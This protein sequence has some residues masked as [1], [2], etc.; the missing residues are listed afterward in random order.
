MTVSRNW[1]SRVRIAPARPIL[2]RF[3]PVGGMGLVETTRTSQRSGRQH[4]PHAEGLELQPLAIDDLQRRRR[5]VD[6][7]AQLEEQ[8]RDRKSEFD[9]STTAW[10]ISRLERDQHLGAIDQ[11][12][13][14]PRDPS[15]PSRT[16]SGTIASA[17]SGSAHDQPNAALRATVSAMPTVLSL[18]SDPKPKRR[19]PASSTM[20]TASA[21]RSAPAMVPVRR[22]AAHHLRV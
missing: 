12:S 5:L 7:I 19:R 1:G 20:H 18:A 3:S 15:S 16:S 13:R 17:A 8:L 2:R 6:R 10:P 4:R 22:S 11:H 14:S 9:V 21:S